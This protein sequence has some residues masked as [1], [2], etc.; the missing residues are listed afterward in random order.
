MT[1]CHTVTMSRQMVTV[2]RQIV[3]L[4]ATRR[5][6]CRGKRNGSFLAET[7]KMAAEP[8]AS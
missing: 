8:V 4:P 7:A 1:G 3:T 2:W 6:I 5:R